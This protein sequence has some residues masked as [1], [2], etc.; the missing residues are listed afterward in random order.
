MISEDSVLIEIANEYGTPTYIFDIDEL[1]ERINKIK[2]ILGEN[3]ALCYAMKA[4]PF[5]VDAMKTLVSKYEVCSP[6]EFAICER[7]NI[8]MKSIVLSG[9]NKIIK[10]RCFF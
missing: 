2:Q 4:N 1:T 8:D 7:E 9:V 3:I 6:G 5:L 10:Y